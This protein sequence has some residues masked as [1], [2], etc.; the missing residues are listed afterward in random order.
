MYIA[1]KFMLRKI[2]LARDNQRIHSQQSS[3]IIKISRREEAFGVR[4]Y[5]LSVQSELRALFCSCKGI[6]DEQMN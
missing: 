5:F 2:Q 4:V 1:L 3:P 6:E